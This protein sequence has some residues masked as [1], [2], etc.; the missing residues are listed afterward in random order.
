MRRDGDGGARAF[1]Q[2][3]HLV[4]SAASGLL[5]HVNKTNIN[6]ALE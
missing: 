6:N 2:V 3:R 4:A 5:R 1:E